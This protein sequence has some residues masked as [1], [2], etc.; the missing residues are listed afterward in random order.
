MKN[1]LYILILGLI[2]SCS[3]EKEQINPNFLYSDGVIT[4]T[5]CYLYYDSIKG[6]NITF[7]GTCT[8][9]TKYTHPSVYITADM[10]WGDA[11]LIGDKNTPLSHT[12]NLNDYAKYIGYGKV[13]NTRVIFYPA[14]S[15]NSVYH[16]IP[17]TFGYLP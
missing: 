15:N 8:D 16:N 1:I 3:K 13:K 6:Y 5:K 2:I 4:F 9:W 14:A 11:Y 7:E 10:K 17:V 12:E